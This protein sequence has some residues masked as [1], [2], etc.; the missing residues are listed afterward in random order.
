VKNYAVTEKTGK[1][2]GVKVVEEGIDVMMIS[3]DGTIIR[4][5]VTGISTYGRATQGV[6]L[7][8]LGEEASVIAIALMVHEEEEDA[9][10]GAPAEQAVPEAE[11]EE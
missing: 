3:S 1:V 6:R 5:A 4:T 11:T 9:E 10:G 7:M 8:R 2:A